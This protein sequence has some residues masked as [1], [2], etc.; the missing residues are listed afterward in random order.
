MRKHIRRR[1]PITRKPRTVVININN[2]IGPLTID[3][4]GPRDVAKQVEAAILKIL[5]SAASD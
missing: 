2:L 1:K 4:D 3:G 5:N